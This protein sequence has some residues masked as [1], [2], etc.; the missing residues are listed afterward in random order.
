MSSENGNISVLRDYLKQS[1]YAVVL[2]GAGISTPSGI[3]D[4]RSD[5]GLYNEN[6][7]YEQ[8]LSIDYFNRHPDEFYRFFK[9]KMIYPNAQPNLAH[10]FI[11]KLE[12]NPVK[13]VI[14]QNIDKLHQRAGSKNVIEVHG[15]L[16]EYTC[17]KCGAKANLDEIMRQDGTPMCSCGGVFR[18]DIVFYGQQLNEHNIEQSIM[19]IRAADLIIV[20]GTS[21]TVYPVAGFINYRSRGARLVIINRDPTPFDGDADLVLHDDI[22]DVAKACE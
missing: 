1:R 4:F 17:A 9:A 15:N 2:T 6:I 10:E 18:P 12:P 5:K 22:I 16:L 11:A 13:A 14:T 21:L 19:H 8:M 7:N 3:P 20:I